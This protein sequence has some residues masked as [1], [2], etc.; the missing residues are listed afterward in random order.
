MNAF[1]LE[2]IRDL[3]I[4]MNQRGYEFILSKFSFSKSK[5]TKSSFNDTNINGSNWWIIPVVRARWNFLIT[6]DKS[7]SYEKYISG[8]YNNGQSVKMISVGSG[9]CSHEIELAK[10][11]PNWHITCLDFSEKL[12]QSAAETANKQGL[13]NME[14]LA[15]DIYKYHLPDDYY[16]IVLFNSSLHHFKNLNEFTGK[17]YKSMALSGK[18]IIN[19][20]VGPNRLQYDKEQ[21]KEINQCLQLI[22][23][24]YRKTYKTS[25]YKNRYYGSGIFRMIISDPS[26]CV[27]SASILPAIRMY[28]KT[29]EERGYGGNLLMPVLKDISHHFV[30]LDDKKES[31]IENVFRYEDNYLTQNSSDFVFGIYEK[32]R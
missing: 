4:K 30:D 17:I 3:F 20:Y 24:E 12:L 16:D 29:I 2:D 9:V 14:F 8:K 19:E 21:L 26:E 23:R 27:D 32:T 25:I 15:E 6:G 31:C 13:T 1:T 5:R 22:D 10:L 18:L 28:F 7:I 11:N